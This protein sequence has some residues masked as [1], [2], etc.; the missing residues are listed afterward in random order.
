MCHY[1]RMWAISQ[2]IRN[3][4]SILRTYSR[5]AYTENDE[6]HVYDLIVLNYESICVGYVYFAINKAAECT[7]HEEQNNKQIAWE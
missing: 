1:C 7:E 3:N 5:Q 6:D 4:I 2:W